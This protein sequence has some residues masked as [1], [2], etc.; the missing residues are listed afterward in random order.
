MTQYTFVAMDIACHR[1][2]SADLHTFPVRSAMC[3]VVC[4]SS[5]ELAA[6]RLAS[7][8]GPADSAMDR[9]AAGSEKPARPETQKKPVSTYAAGAA[10]NPIMLAQVKVCF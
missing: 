8:L 10:D 5:C 6:R 3:F 2:T 4:S 7:R 1:M 9:F